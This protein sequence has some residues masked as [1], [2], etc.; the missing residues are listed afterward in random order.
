M[1]QNLWV[2][3]EGLKRSAQCGY[4]ELLL[5]PSDTSSS[6]NCTSHTRQVSLQPGLDHLSPIRLSCC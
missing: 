3:S 4:H 2:F 5:H 6:E 1:L